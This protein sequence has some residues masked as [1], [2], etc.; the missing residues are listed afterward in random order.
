MYADSALCD[1]LFLKTHGLCGSF[2][3]HLSRKGIPVDQVLRAVSVITAKMQSDLL[4]CVRVTQGTARHAHALRAVHTQDH[5][6][7]CIIQHA[8]DLGNRKTDR[9][10]LWILKIFVL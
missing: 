9:Y 3:S 8:T 7:P 10:K 1:S 5:V 4:Q 2:L 6:T